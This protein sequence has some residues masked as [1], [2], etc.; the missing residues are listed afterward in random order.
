MGVTR[1]RGLP[2]GFAAGFTR[3]PLTARSLDPDA[4]GR[5]LAEALG[6]PDAE[7]V[8]LK[9]VHG[10]RVLTFEEPPR[11]RRNTLFGDGDAVLTRVQNVLL[12]VASADCVPIVLVDP[13]SDWIAAV[14]AGWRGTAARVLDAALDALERRGVRVAGLSAAFGPSI[15]G[16]RYE[17]GPEVVTALRAAYRG[18][19]VPADSVR[20]GDAD[21]AFVDVAAFNAAA[22]RARGIRAERMATSALCTRATIDLPSWRRDEAATGRILTGIVR[23]PG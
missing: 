6:A 8:R 4:A 11:E 7:V 1:L 15:S 18:V 17:V 9:Q 5:A 22:L 14:H 13:D 2:P 12:A 21:R 19:A 10:A 23:L 16:E 3:G 20:V